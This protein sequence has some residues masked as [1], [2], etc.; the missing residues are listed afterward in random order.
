MIVQSVSADGET[1]DL[2]FT[3]G[4]SDLAR[5]TATLEAMRRRGR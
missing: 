5:T 3:V 1:T 4:R 2:T